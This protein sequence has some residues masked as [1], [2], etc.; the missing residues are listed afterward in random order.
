ML[1]RTLYS[2]NIDLLTY[3]DTKE[4]GELNSRMNANIDLEVS[5]MISSDSY[6]LSFSC[7]FGKGAI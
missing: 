5:N 1:Q 6:E 3:S 7:M 4:A 2:F